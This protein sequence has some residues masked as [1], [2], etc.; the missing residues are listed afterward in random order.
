ME[1]KNLDKK[2]CVGLGE[3]L[4]M[5]SLLV[6]NSV[7]LLPISLTTQVSMAYILWL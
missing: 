7:V 4:L 1:T 5:F 3:I 2:Y 6:L